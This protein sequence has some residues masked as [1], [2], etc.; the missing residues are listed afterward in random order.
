[1]DTTIELGAIKSRPIRS[2]KTG[3]PLNDLELVDV[4]LKA[5]T[6]YQ[7]KTGKHP[8]VPAPFFQWLKDIKAENVTDICAFKNKTIQ[9]S[10]D[11]YSIFK[12]VK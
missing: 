8:P 1:M 9:K 2:D 6:D 12:N 4:A 3:K 11:D 10:V 5:L 7:D